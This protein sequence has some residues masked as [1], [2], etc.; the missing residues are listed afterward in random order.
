MLCQFSALWTPYDIL[1]TQVLPVC[2]R[3]SKDVLLELEIFL[4]SYVG[5]SYENEPFGDRM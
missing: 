1:N 4:L 3:V 5:R 2:R